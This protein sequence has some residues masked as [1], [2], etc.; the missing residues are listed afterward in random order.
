MNDYERFRRFPHS[1]STPHC[2]IPKGDRNA[3][4][5]ISHATRADL[6]ECPVAPQSTSGRDLE[7]K[8][9]GGQ[10]RRRIAV[11]VGFTFF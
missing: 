11:A 5:T 6:R 4:L 10:R 1:G 3:L 9:G 2:L 8:A 7:A